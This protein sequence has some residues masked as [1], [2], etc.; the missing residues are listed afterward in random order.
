VI[1]PDATIACDFMLHRF[2][3]L[4]Q[5]LR[6]YPERMLQNLALLRGVIYSQSVLLELAKKGMDRQAA[7]VI[8]QRNAMKTYEQG[9]DFKDALLA[10]PEL[11]KV[12]SPQE[13]ET[14]FSTEQHLRH[15][16]AIFDRVFG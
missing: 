13:I 10:D 16:D 6:V 15:V 5:D 1:A 8:V 2:A 3:G 7:Y 14:C 9:I 11:L 12:L 4:M